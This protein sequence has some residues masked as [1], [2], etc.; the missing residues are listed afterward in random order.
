MSKVEMFAKKDMLN[1]DSNIIAMKTQRIVA[2]EEVPEFLEGQS[3]NES[4]SDSD[5]SVQSQ[6]QSQ[7]QTQN[8]SSSSSSMI[9][10]L[11]MMFAHDD[12]QSSSSNGHSTKSRITK[13]FKLKFLDAKSQLKVERET[14]GNFKLAV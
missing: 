14:L 8:S 13:P 10:D 2:V 1:S 11:S 12:D 7:S 3:S 9:S 5:V 6:S 4:N